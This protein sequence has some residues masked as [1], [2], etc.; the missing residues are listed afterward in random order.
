MKKV[1][2][3]SVAKLAGVS[4]ATVS[5]VLNGKQ[6]VSFS[7]E[8]IDKVIVAARQLNYKLPATSPFPGAA[9][10]NLIGLLVPTL[11]NPYYPMITQIIEQ[12]ALSQGYHILLCN[13]N[14][15][16]NTEAYYLNLLS[17]NLVNSIIYTFSPGFPD[18]IKKISD[19][20]PI[21][22]I[23]E[24][25]ESLHID[26]VGLSS[27]KAGMLIA[28]HL[29]DLGHKKIAF[30]STP[31]DSMTFSRKRRLDGIVDKLKEHDLDQQ[32]VVKSASE[33]HEVPSNIYEI[34]VGY[35]LT[36]EL[37]AESDVTAI[38]AVNDITA[39]G[40]VNAL[41]SMHYKIPQQISV[42]GFDNIFLSAITHPTLT[43]IDHCVDHR[44]KTAV[45][46][47]IERMAHRKTDSPIEKSLI[48]NIYKIEYQ[49]QIIIRNSTQAPPN[50][51]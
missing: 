31:I 38:I 49:P 51:P 18:K 21:V 17:K 12:K 5:L 34:E 23:G 41:N 26:T 35:R 36:Q 42:C 48:T 30:V 9:N 37:M 13:T 8:T 7:H 10:T 40:V 28:D 39:C 6:N 15:N 20:L 1:T 22:L 24:K 14:R 44:A 2:S 4:Q 27:Y 47:A 29:I 33:E 43:T 11:S 45:D 16:L 25:D 3:Q 19:S 46:I 50:N 32:L